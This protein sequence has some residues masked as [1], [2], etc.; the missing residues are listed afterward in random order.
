MP[1]DHDEQIQELYELVISVVKES[2]DRL[3]HL[4]IDVLR[5]E[6][7]SM[8]DIANLCRMF[9]DLAKGTEI[10]GE[11]SEAVSVIGEAAQAVH[12]GDSNRLT[13]CAYHLEDF[14]SR[15]DT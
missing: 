8:E 2:I 7:P 5:S 11:F 3:Y 4:P 14:L 10:G 6:T 1:K 15:M 12:D 13:D 9:L